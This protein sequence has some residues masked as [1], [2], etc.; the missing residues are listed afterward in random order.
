MKPGDWKEYKNKMKNER[1]KD[2]ARSIELKKIAA[3][4]MITAI[5]LLLLLSGGLF[6][7][8]ITFASIALIIFIY[9]RYMHRK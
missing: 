2:A 4:F 3:Q 7:P 9:F 5:C 8:V 6:Y 1:I